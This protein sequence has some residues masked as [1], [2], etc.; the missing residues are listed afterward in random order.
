M[1]ARRKCALV[2]A[3]LLLLA[4]GLM[5]SA[6]APDVKIVTRIELA[7]PAPPSADLLV[8]PAPTVTAGS[9]DVGEVLTRLASDN[10]SLRRTV[11]GWQLWY[12][13]MLRSIRGANNAKP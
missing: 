4:L 10:K 6:C 8:E 12:A 5:L 7:E 2:M 9:K 1:T 3:G 13:D 11:L